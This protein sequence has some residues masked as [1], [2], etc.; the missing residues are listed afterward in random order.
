MQIALESQALPRVSLCLPLWN[1]APSCWMSPAGLCGLLCGRFKRQGSWH[2]PHQIIQLI[3]VFVS[4]TRKIL[5]GRQQL[6]GVDVYL[7]VRLLYFGCKSCLHYLWGL[8]L[9]GRRADD[10]NWDVHVTHRRSIGRV[11]T[12]LKCAMREIRVTKHIRL[13]ARA[14]YCHT[15]TRPLW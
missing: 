8:E 15:T 10:G 14:G 12:T 13:S 5:R 2:T 1:E 9:P 3:C 4:G 11:D 6:N 7:L